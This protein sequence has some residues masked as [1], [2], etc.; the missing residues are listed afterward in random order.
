[1]TTPNPFAAHVPAEQQQPAAPAPAAPAQAPNP[2][3]Q[4]QAA[5]AAPA[6]P[7]PYAQQQAP[8]APQAYAPPAPSY[9]P[10]GY[11]PQ[12]Y[13]SQAPAAA[14]VQA[15]APP[16][17]ATAPQAAPPVLDPGRLASAGA[18]VVGEGRGAKLPDMYGR[19]V[20]FFPLSIARVPRNPQFIT[21]EQRASGNTDQDR[22]TATVVVLD[23]GRLGDMTPIAFGGAPHALPPTPHTDSAPLPYVRKAM[24]INQSRLISQLRDSLPAGPG[25]APGMV[26][27]RLAKAGPQNN[28]PW[29]LI[30]A[31]AEEIDLVTTYLNL[32]AAGQY[33]H[34]LG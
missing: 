8:A 17:P 5:P 22:L 13:A 28:D 16:A 2:F 24:W 10:Q 33:P 34:P 32:V 23:G 21:A 30:G 27:G 6:A 31:T 7:N 20:V 15:Y 9:A 29:Y 18:P 3:A 11:A 1:M 25:Q 4:Q 12:G 14:P 26:A 19:L